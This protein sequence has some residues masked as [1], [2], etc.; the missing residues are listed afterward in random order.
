MP[1]NGAYVEIT[2]QI[3]S[4][5]KKAK[6]MGSVLFWLLLILVSCYFF[7]WRYIEPFDLRNLYPNGE[8]N[9]APLV[10]LIENQLPLPRA[11]NDDNANPIYI[12]HWLNPACR[13]T[14]LSRLFIEQLS[15]KT[16]DDGVWHIVVTPP[17]QAKSLRQ[18]FAQLSNEVRAFSVVE[19]SAIA[20]RQSQVL[21]PATPAAIV[22]QRKTQSISYLGPHSSGV[23]C[24]N[25]DSFVELV[26]NNLKFGFDP[27]LIE[28]ERNGCFCPW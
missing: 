7:L 26:L 22:Y 3:N 9:P 2:W 25:G 1:Y 21:I 20:Y 4:Q 24:G 10:E 5:M 14:L 23:V 6:V 11:L 16:I 28:L 8:I 17:K 12:L 27:Q 18:S 13:C 19:L 15:R